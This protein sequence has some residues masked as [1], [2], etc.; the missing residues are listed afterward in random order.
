MIVAATALF[1]ALGTGAYAAITHL[2]K[3]TVGGN[4]IK[5]QGVKTRNYSKGSILGRFIKENQVKTPAIHNAAVT[6]G[7]TS[8]IS[9]NSQSSSVSTT[10]SS[11]V[12]L[13]G[14][15]VT[16]TVPDGGVVELFAQ[17]DISVSGGGAP[18]GK[19]DLFEPSL[20]S[21]PASILSSPSST[22]QTRYSS[23]GSNDFNG[24]VN[25]TRGGWVTLAPP[26]GTYTFSLR[27][28]TSGGTAT[29]QNRTLLVRVTR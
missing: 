22:F 15:S 3:N 4:A 24:V 21:H 16:V 19:V 14:P 29:F 10:S 6:T 20:V 9:S 26:P 13:G 27:Y 2:P 17:A 1:V 12:D 8:F 7:K 18:G 25:A 28:E 11:P 5:A 23:P